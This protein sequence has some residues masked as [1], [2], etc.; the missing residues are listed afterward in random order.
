[1]I[2]RFG[3]APEVVQLVDADVPPLA[4]GQVRVRMLMAAINP[5]DLVT[6]SGAYRSRTVLPFVGGFEGVGVVEEVNDPGSILAP[7]M[8]VLPLGSAGAWQRY[9]VTEA[10]WCFCV[11][12]ALTDA[13]AATSYVNPFTA[14]LMTHGCADFHPKARL[15]LS[16][17]KSVIALMLIRLANLQGIAPVV[18]LRQ[19]VP[20]G[21]FDGLEIAQ[22]IIAPNDAD[23]TAELARLRPTLALDAV[24]GQTGQSMYQALSDGGLMIQYGLLSGQQIRLDQRPQ[25]QVRFELFVLRN[26]V[27][28]A[29]RDAIAQTMAATTKAILEGVLASAV[30]QIY[31]LADYADAFRHEGQRGRQGK[32]LLRV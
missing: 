25:G 24:G 10:K 26:W 19:P 1:M 4:P 23:C 22:V 8:R 30:D 17:G 9:K 14:W 21:F 32:V 28:A 11:D 3:P 15:V 29:S 2:D 27:H 18:V 16:A 20:D 13:Q 12:D 6:L 5:S 31:D 7:G